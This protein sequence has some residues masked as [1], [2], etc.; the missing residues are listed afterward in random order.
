MLYGSLLIWS[1][2]A[3]VQGKFQKMTC[4]NLS[5]LLIHTSINYHKL[6]LEYVK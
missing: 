3:I 2:P 4:F 6:L 5:L 1:T